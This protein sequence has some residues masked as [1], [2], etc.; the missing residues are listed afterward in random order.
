MADVVNWYDKIG[1]N[2]KKSK[3]PKNWKNH[4]IYHNS[5]ILCVGGTGTGK[6][7]AFVDYLS[8][9]SGEFHKII[10]I[11]FSTLDEPLYNFLQSKNSEIEFINSIEDVPSLNEFDDENKD[12]PKLIVFDDFINLT[13]KEFKKVN[14]YLISGRKFGF[15]VWLMAQE[16]VSIPK[17]ITRN[18]NYFILNKINDAVSVDRIFKNHNLYG[19]DKDILKKAY[20]LCIKEPLHFFL[21]DLKSR[22]PQDRYREGWLNFLKLKE[23]Q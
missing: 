23:D 6:T 20:Y 16:Y 22:D 19:A 11:S 5:M 21:L 7:N 10:I 1:A 8:R 17:I 9:T 13:T 18:I 14:P 2:E 15:S 4:H 3:L 12:K